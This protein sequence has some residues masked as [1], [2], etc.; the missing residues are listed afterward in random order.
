MKKSRKRDHV[1]EGHGETCMCK[2]CRAQ[3]EA[4]FLRKRPQ[5]R[6]DDYKYFVE[7]ETTDDY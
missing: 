6:P 3:L 5:I 2:K 7:E 4:V 1:K